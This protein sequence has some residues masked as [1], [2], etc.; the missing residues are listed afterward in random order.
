MIETEAK[1]IEILQKLPSEGP[2]LDYKEMPYKPHDKLNFLKDVIAMLNAEAAMDKDK[3]II[4]GVEDKSRQLKGIVEEAWRDDNEWQNLLSKI[5]PKPIDV[6]TGMVRFENKMFG[7][8]YISSLNNEWIY[9]AETPV[10]PD[11]GQQA[12]ESNTIFKG[13]AFTRR[14]STN[15]VLFSKD[16]QRILEKKIQSN[17][18]KGNSVIVDSNYDEILM[19]T[20]GLIGIWNEDYDGDV[21]AVGK[22]TGLSKDELLIKIRRYRSESESVLLYSNGVWKTSNHLELL[23]READKIYDNHIEAFF[24]CL[25]NV[26]LEIN[27]KYNLDSDKRHMATFFLHGQRNKYSNAIKEGL[28][29]TLAI[30]GN[31]KEVFVNCSDN[32][33]LNGV[34]QFIR[35][36]FKI[37]D[38]RGYASQADYFQYIGEACPS[39]FL[40]EIIE[41]TS[42]EDN[43]FVEFLNEKEQGITVTQ[44][45]YQLLWT[46]SN[47]AKLEQYFSK[48]MLALF[49]LA[50]YNT[51]FGD[52]LVGVVLPWYPQTHAPI[53]IRVGVFNGLAKEDINL[54]WKLLM[55][56]MP[57]VTTTGSPIQKTKVLKVEDIPE[58]VSTKDYMEASLGYIN[59]AIEISGNDVNR[60]C[61]LLR[62]IDDVDIELQNKIVTRISDASINLSLEE[63]EYLW[64]K[65]QD[66]LVRH[67][68]FSDADWALGEERLKSIDKLASHVLSDSR[69]AYAVRLFRKDQYSLMEEKDDYS[70]G[71]KKLRDKQTIILKEIYSKSGIRGIV[72]FEKEVE[73]IGAIGACLG[74]FIDDSD[75]LYIISKSEEIEN[76]D[77]IRN[78]FLTINTE[79]TIEIICNEPDEIQAKILS[80]LPLTKHTLAIVE[81]LGEGAQKI[82]WN[83]THVWGIGQ[84]CFE[85]YERAVERL[86]A[87][88]RTDKSI[89][90][91]YNCLKEKREIKLSVV[92]ET[93][94]LN[95]EVASTQSNN[96]LDEYYI[97]HLIKWLQEQDVDKDTMVLIE[98]KYLVFLEEREGYPPKFLW[99]EMSSNPEYYMGIIKLICG[100]EDDFSESKEERTRIVSQ[101]YKLLYVWKRVPGL[102][103]DGTLD[104][105]VLDNW[106]SFVTS[107]SKKHDVESMAL[108]Y[109]GRAAFYAP[110]DEDGFFIEKHVA[111]VLQEDKEGLA[112]SGY[113]TEAFNSR[114][115]YNV[116]I[117]GQAEFELEKSYQ[118]KANAADEVGMFRLAETLRKI[119]RVYHEEGEHN[120]KYGLSFGSE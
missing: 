70:L 62:V 20:L 6:R 51:S 72:G 36:F 8:I 40:D 86:N 87:S 35:E 23:L 108:N 42:K 22:I 89:F 11:R 118:E 83:L 59:I 68:K 73:N 84:D 50:K 28:A 56:L 79:R 109:F 33:I 69:H 75:V 32:K 26:F 103:M 82:F 119:A 45:G 49:Q 29:E 110:A 94:N 24:D 18:S 55:K 44:Y 1:V 101:C 111:N 52:A 71:E 65:I 10:F 43:A 97:Q 27:P 90:I 115:V 25:K 13:Q 19:G 74:S 107:E 41:L 91:L 12:K 30:L 120:I 39:V 85:I 102:C 99:D 64:D 58:T 80:F 77:L 15:V 66:F 81:K 46:I 105:T 67:R 78:F 116:D 60:L 14:G 38:W 3:F 104:A 16:R 63:K 31:N 37:D 5:S 117:T 98:W 2:N 93:L 114:G 48:A 17:N 4:F 100:K 96:T 61:D 53:A 54:T 47:I 57:R 95:A 34:C 112:L 88:R 92:V 9:E 106:I 76:D 113:F 7:Y 21:E